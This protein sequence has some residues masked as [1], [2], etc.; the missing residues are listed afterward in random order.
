MVKVLEL[1]SGT[2]SVGKVAKEMGWEVVSLDLQNADINI[3]I[4]NWNYTEFKPNTFH[5]I[6]A[7]P[8]CD[9]FSSIKKTH[10]G[11][12]NKYGKIIT[13]DD[14]QADMDNIGLPILNKTL[15]IILYF[16]PEYYFIENPQS[17]SMKQYIDLPF[18]DVDY[19]QYANWGYRKRTRVW[20]NLR[21]F[22]PKKCRQDC[23]SCVNGKH[24]INIG[25]T[26]KD[27]ISGV[28]SKYTKLNERYRIPPNL[29][30][31][32]FNLYL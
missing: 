21:G 29:I 17:S 30:K 15:E 27:R 16:N 3:N 2:H 32:L 28:K 12:K 9:T 31:S 23:T 7:S 20:T 13:R 11:R 10:L 24:L 18:Y 26:R 22:I 25:M 19:C 6:W 4:L 5:I 1:F 14:I 8:P